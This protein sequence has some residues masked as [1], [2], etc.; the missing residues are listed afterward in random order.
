MY[1]ETCLESLR[2]VTLYLTVIIDVG[3]F[4][5]DRGDEISGSDGGENGNDCL[6]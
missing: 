6:L 3:D 2:Y 1:N 4:G 5:D